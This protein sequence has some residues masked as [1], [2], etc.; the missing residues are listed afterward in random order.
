MFEE[1]D[2]GSDKVDKWSDKVDKG[3][4]LEVCEGLFL[5]MYSSTTHGILGGHIYI[6]LY[7]EPKSATCKCLYL[8]PQDL[9]LST[10]T[11]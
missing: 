6:V 5:A 3:S 1:V 9:S 7:M 8:Q 2:K 10:S 11:T 4:H